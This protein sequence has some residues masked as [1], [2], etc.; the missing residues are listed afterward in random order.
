MYA[1]RLC[2]ALLLITSITLGQTREKGFDAYKAKEINKSDLWLNGTAMTLKSLKGKVVLLDFWAFDCEPCIQAMPH[3]VELHDKYGKNGLVVIGVH[4]PRA[5]YEKSIEGLKG[6]MA[7]MNIRFPVVV[8]EKQKIWR[9]YR[10]D[11]WPSQFIVDREGFVR[12]S[13]G[14]VGRYD[15]M[16][17]VIQKLLS[18]S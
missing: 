11:L 10:C 9:D 12:Y 3:V 7:R 5:D 4:T 1:T 18:D 16:E 13:H 8:D 14:G 2:L 17:T 15:D 6:A